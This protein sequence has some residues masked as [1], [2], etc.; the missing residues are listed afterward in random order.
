MW[1]QLLDVKLTFSDFVLVGILCAILYGLSSLEIRSEQFEKSAD[2]RQM[3]DL[4]VATFFA[5]LGIPLSLICGVIAESGIFHHLTSLLAVLPLV[6]VITFWVKHHRFGSQLLEVD[7]FSKYAAGYY[8]HT[9][10]NCIQLYEDDGPSN[11][12]PSED[13]IFEACSRAL[14]P[15]TALKMIA[16]TE[17][18]RHLSVEMGIQELLDTLAFDRDKL[19]GIL[20]ELVAGRVLKRESIAGELHY[21]TIDR[22]NALE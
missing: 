5:F 14:L 18:G 11:Q 12:G 6:A 17:A 10:L 22:R 7:G 15:Q 2:D 16:M 20:E 4:K 19:K 13:H 3:Q 21:I 1:E 8:R 9:V